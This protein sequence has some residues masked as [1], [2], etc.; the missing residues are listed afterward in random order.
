MFQFSRSARMRRFGNP[1]TL[2]P[3][4]LILLISGVSRLGSAADNPSGTEESWQVIYL[5]GKQIGYGF[6]IVEPTG[7]QFSVRSETH[8]KFQR[9]GQ[10]LQ[11]VERLETRESATGE[12][13]EFRYRMENPPASGTL[14]VGKV[15]KGKL[16]L[17]TTV[18]GT[19][20]RTTTDWDADLRSPAWIDRSLAKFDWSK[21][22]RHSFRAYVPQLQRVATFD[23]ESAGK[24]T[25]KLLDG[26]TS[27]PMQQLKVSN[28][29]TP[30]IVTEAWIEGG[31]EVVKTATTLLGLPMETFSVSRERAVAAV[32]VEDFDL[33][34]QTLVSVDP[35]ENPHSTRRIVYEIRDKRANPADIFAASANQS[36]EVVDAKTIRLS[37]SAVPIPDDGRSTKDPGEQYLVASQFLQLDDEGLKK[38]A[39][40]A[41]P[42]SEKP[43]EIARALEKLVYQRLTS[44]NFSTAMASAAEVARTLQGD[45]TEHAVLLA[46]L[47]R[48]RGIPS[49]LAAGL[50][51]VRNPKPSFG[52]HM[53]TEAWLGDR[54]VPLDGTLARGGIGA[55]HLTVATSSFA[56]SDP[57]P[58]TTFLPLLLSSGDLSIRILSNEP[59]E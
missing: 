25:T 46:A 5:G 48:I 36:V 41:A 37:V 50:V 23:L 29:L 51:Y 13:I 26:S 44:K 45:C 12:M 28:S 57:A 14:V 38:L 30:G 6:T 8:L 22:P 4:L 43:E 15:D 56:D 53:W 34:V 42:G 18:D 9:F 58:M 19:A 10:T 47:L 31:T 11:I 33:A 27:R 17:T 39:Q 49:R 1:V 16:V 7:D 54:W 3:I 2:L 55:A 59:G 20:R 40:E 21:E 52:G 32:P 35:I 24:S